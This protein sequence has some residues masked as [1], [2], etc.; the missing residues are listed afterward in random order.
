MDIGDLFDFPASG[1]N[2]SVSPLGGTGS[3]EWLAL[4]AKQA[5]E[6]ATDQVLRYGLVLQALVRVGE[7]KGLFTKQELIAE[8]ESID[9]EDGKRTGKINERR[10]PKKC[11]ACGKNSA[12]S[13]LK[14]L[15]CGAELPRRD[16]V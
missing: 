14:C 13:A 5:S 16:V 10:E 2:G 1:G 3:P 15:Y 12:A 9:A 11:P 8:I 7:R 6:K 4:D